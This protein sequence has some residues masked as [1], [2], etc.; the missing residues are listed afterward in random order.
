MY[1]AIHELAHLMTKE[2]GHTTTFWQNFKFLLQEAITINIY[3]DYDFNKK[4]KDY[5]G[6]KI[7]SSILS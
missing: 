2:V 5:C 6:I 3:K 7:T 1:V 4:P